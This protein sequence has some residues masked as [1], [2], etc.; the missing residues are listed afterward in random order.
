MTTETPDL[1]PKIIE[2]DNGVYLYYCKIKVLTLCN[3]KQVNSDTTTTDDE[4][5]YCTIPSEQIEIINKLLLDSD[6]LEIVE[7][8][9]GGS[10]LVYYEDTLLSI[11]WSDDCCLEFDDEFITKFKL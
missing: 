8:G 10:T 1:R 11:V 2:D 6:K 4:C 5:Y 7:G 3:C 9:Q